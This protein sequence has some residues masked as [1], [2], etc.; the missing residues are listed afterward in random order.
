MQSHGMACIE[1]YRFEGDTED[2][3]TLIAARYDVPPNAQWRHISDNCDYPYSIPD[4]T[5]Q[6]AAS[7]G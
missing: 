7:G 2:S 4:P 6:R 1:Q 5:N 3:H